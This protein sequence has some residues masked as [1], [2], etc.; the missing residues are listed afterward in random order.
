MRQLVDA[1]PRVALVSATDRD[2]PLLPGTVELRLPQM[3][4]VVLKL[5]R[6]QGQK[7]TVIEEAFATTL[8]R[9]LNG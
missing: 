3:R 2:G 7:K 6:P 8:W 5:F 4:E 9:C 1:Q